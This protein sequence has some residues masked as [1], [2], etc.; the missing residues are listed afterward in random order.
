MPTEAHRYPSDWPQ[1]S[2]SIREAAGW[3][4]EDCGKLCRVPKEK[5]T[6]YIERTG[7]PKKDVLQHPQR[8]T[9]DGAHLDQNP[10]NSDRNN[11]KALCR[12]CHLN[13]DRKYIGYNMMQRRERNGQL[14][15]MLL[16]ERWPTS[17]INRNAFSL[18]GCAEF[19]IA[20]QSASELLVSLSY[21]APFKTIEIKLAFLENRELKEFWHEYGV[22]EISRELTCLPVIIDIYIKCQTVSTSV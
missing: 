18:Q 10:G 13:G 21:Y 22:K 6:D 8:Y 14:I 20:V 1:L 9:L 15:L 11:L 3:A 2:I 12:V 7:Y 5:L 17:D 19:F 16:E 4:C